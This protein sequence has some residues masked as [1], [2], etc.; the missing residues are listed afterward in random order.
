MYYTSLVEYWRRDRAGERPG[1]FLHTAGERER[2]EV[3]RGVR[4]AVA[5]VEALVESWEVG[6]RTE[7]L[8]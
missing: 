2:E 6:G 5:L 7:V 8:R 3:E 4:V 1:V